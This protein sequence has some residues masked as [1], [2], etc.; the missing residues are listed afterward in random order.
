MNSHFRVRGREPLQVFAVAGKDSGSTGLYGL[1]HDEGIHSMS[2]AGGSQKPAGGA[3][4]DLACFRYRTDRLHHSVDRR[5]AWSPADSLGHDDDRNLDLRT[6]FQGSGQKSLRPRI[7]PGQSDNRS[8][9]K[10]QALRR[11]TFFSPGIG[12]S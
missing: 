1:G 12:H 3:S 2:R 11:L 7:S 10:D 4:M 8:R 6:Q 5:V 9:I